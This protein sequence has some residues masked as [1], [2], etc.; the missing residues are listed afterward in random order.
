MEKNETMYLS[1]L[2]SKKIILQKGNLNKAVGK[3]LP[4]RL[5]NWIAFNSSWDDPISSWSIGIELIRRNPLKTNI[6]S[7]SLLSWI[8]RILE[9]SSLSIRSI[10]L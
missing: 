4:C 7:K 10:S 3:E 1:L 6:K 8:Y 5:Y 9:R 2:N